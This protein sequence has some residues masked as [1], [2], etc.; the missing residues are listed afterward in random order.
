MAASPKTELRRSSRYPQMGV[1]SQTKRKIL[2]IIVISSSQPNCL[3]GQAFRLPL[4]F[5][6][7]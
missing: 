1:I 6:P 4:G 7:A 5:R 3:W 2:K